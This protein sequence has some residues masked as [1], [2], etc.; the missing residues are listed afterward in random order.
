MGL[1]SVATLS[2]TSPLPDLT[3]ADHTMP[4]LDKP[5]Q[6]PAGLQQSNTH[7]TTPHTP[8]RR[9]CPGITHTHRHTPVQKWCI[10]GVPYY[11]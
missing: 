11:M 9:S 8:A 6:T 4:F 3:R 2:H 5:T 1:M 10:G 7:H